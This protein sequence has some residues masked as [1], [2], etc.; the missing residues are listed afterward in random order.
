[1]GL[2]AVVDERSGRGDDVTSSARSAEFHCVSGGLLP[3]A[4]S[5][6]A[7]PQRWPWVIG[8]TC[9]CSCAV[10]QAQYLLCCDTQKVAQRLQT[11]ASVEAMQLVI[12]TLTTL[13]C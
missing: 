2:H 5:L 11:C 9:A 4:V 3:A 13:N 10:L 12:C 7:L 8:G 1:M 6:Y